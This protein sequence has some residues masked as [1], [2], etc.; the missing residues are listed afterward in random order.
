M[1]PPEG[2]SEDV[3]PGAGGDAKEAARRADPGQDGPAAPSPDALLP[4]LDAGQ[5]DVLREV[6]DAWNLVCGRPEVWRRAL[7]LD[8]SLGDFPAAEDIRP[9]RMGRLVRVQSRQPPPVEAGKQPATPTGQLGYEVRRVLIGP[10]LRSSAIVSE[11]MRKLV[12]LPVLSADALSSVAYG[13]EAM[14]A[15]LVLG[16]SAGLSY[17]LPIAATIAFLM[18]AVGISYRQTIRAYPHG[19]GSYIVASDNLGRVPGLIAAAGLMTDYILTVAVSVA[20]GLEAITSAIPSLSGDTVPIGVGVIAVL[21]AGN[22]RGVRQAGAAVRRADLRVHLRD[23]RARR[24]GPD[25][26]RADAA[27]TLRRA[28]RS[29]RP[30]RSARC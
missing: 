21:L 18:L 27:F 30:R 13:P 15:I 10:A 4:K 9:T 6:G 24:C 17:S 28:R 22:L 7:P 1:D 2:Q 14:L 19:G 26:R 8:P 5:I 12:A 29:A 3:R 20:S 11:R 25:R 23:L 16:G